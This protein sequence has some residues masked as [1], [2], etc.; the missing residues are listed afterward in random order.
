MFLFLLYEMFFHIYLYYH[1]F[2]GISSY[3]LFFF[4]RVLIIL[5]IS[6]YFIFPKS[7]IIFF[8]DSHNFGIIN[9]ETFDCWM[10][11]AGVVSNLL[12]NGGFG[13]YE[14]GGLMRLKSIKFFLMR[15][16]ATLKKCLLVIINVQVNI[17]INKK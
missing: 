10:P 2:N 17:H 15:L 6:S 1:I 9:V 3:W 11:T 13:N 8:T 7:H 14:R 16:L 12:L 5:A 4:Y